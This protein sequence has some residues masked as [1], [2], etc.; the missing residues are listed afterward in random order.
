MWVQAGALKPAS[1]SAHPNPCCLY[2]G[3]W[4]QRRHWGAAELPVEDGAEV[5]A[6]GADV[7]LHPRRR[8]WRWRC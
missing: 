6:A 1:C 2:A 3:G 5:E 7:E 4:S 8:R